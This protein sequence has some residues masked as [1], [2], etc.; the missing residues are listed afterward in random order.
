M[1]LLAVDE[2]GQPA[3]AATADELVPGPPTLRVE[4]AALYSCHRVWNAAELPDGNKTRRMIS[5]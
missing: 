4:S 3:V 1:D 5:E 2:W